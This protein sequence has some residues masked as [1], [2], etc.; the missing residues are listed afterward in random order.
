MMPMAVKSVFMSGHLLGGSSRLLSV[1][2]ALVLFLGSF[3]RRLI[4][5]HERRRDAL[6]GDGEVGLRCLVLAFHFKRA[7]VHNACELAQAVEERGEVV[8]G[9]FEFQRD[10]PLG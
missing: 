2:S 1:S 5:Q 4:E 9:T 7:D 8:I 10:R 6:R 3:N